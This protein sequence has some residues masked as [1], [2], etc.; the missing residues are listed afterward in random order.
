M[1]QMQKGVDN[2]IKDE[3]KDIIALTIILLIT[4]GLGTVACILF[5]PLINEWHIFWII[6][7][8][9]FTGVVLGYNVVLTGQNFGVIREK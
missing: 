4:S 6:F 5:Y 8:A 9:V 1:L 3:I 7:F 2:M